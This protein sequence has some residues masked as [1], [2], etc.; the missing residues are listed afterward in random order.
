MSG[1]YR[2]VHYVTDPYNATLPRVIKYVEDE[3]KP[4]Q[5]DFIP[6][7]IELTINRDEIFKGLPGCKH[8]EGTGVLGKHRPCTKCVERSGNCNICKNT[9]LII[10][11]PSKKCKCIWGHDRK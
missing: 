7:R 10:A 1:I 2:Q 4:I 5:L 9:G 3:V 11:M 8:C 6:S